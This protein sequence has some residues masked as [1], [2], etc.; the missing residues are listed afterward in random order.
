MGA[1]N[2]PNRPPHLA[3]QCAAKVFPIGLIHEQWQPQHTEHKAR[4][5]VVRAVKPLPKAQGNQEV[6][7]NCPKT[8]E[9]HREVGEFEL[10]LPHY[11]IFRIKGGDDWLANFIEHGQNRLI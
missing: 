5:C 6:E 11:W 3:Q 4:L 8:E 2:Q 9:F 10:P 1:A 7:N